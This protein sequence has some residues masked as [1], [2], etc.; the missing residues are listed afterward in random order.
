MPFV[1][2][3]PSR[4]AKGAGVA[5]PPFLSLPFPAFPAGFCDTFR[6][7]FVFVGCGAGGGCRLLLRQSKRPRGEGKGCHQLPLSPDSVIPVHGSHPGWRVTGAELGWRRQIHPANPTVFQGEAF[8]AGSAHA[9]IR[10]D[11]GSAST[12]E[13]PPDSQPL[14]GLK[15]L[16]GGR[17][18]RAASPAWLSGDFQISSIDLDLILDEQRCFGEQIV[19]ATVWV[20]R[21]R[22]SPGI[23][24]AGLQPHCRRCSHQY[25]G[26][27][28]AVV[29][30]E[31]L[32]R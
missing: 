27:K 26:Y 21:G 18:G 10:R 13:R 30:T 11:P 12:P 3:V 4:S 17:L 29:S 20:G 7:H 32:R 9:G 1:A 28:P 6:W 15:P 8:R 19:T 22:F 23:L 25:S 2:P 5:L 24:A 31:Q 16:R 14:P